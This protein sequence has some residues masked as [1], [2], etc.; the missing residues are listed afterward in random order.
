M[1]EN[2]PVGKRPRIKW[3]DFDSKDVE[4]VDTGVQCREVVKDKDR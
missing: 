2:N 1:I 3:E 4:T